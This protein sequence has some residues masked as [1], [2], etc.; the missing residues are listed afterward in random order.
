[1]IEGKNKIFSL[2]TYLPIGKIVVSERGNKQYFN[3]GPV[4][5]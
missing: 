4:R 2:P 3:L 1:M 5:K